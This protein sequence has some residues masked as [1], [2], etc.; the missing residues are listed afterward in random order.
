MAVGSQ[1]PGMPIWIEAAI[2]TASCPDL[3]QVRGDGVPRGSSPFNRPLRR[4]VGLDDGA[5]V[6]MERIDREPPLGRGRT[7]D[8]HDTEMKVVLSFRA[9]RNNCLPRYLV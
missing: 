5:W 1:A 9:Y 3:V 7:P 6:P 8:V 2:V 4:S